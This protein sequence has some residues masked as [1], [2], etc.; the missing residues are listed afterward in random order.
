MLGKHALATQPIAG[1]LWLEQDLSGEMAAGASLAGRASIEIGAAGIV[2][3]AVSA[4]EGRL[5]RASE[6]AGVIAALSDAEALILRHRLVGGT[7]AATSAATA[8]LTQEEAPR[9]RILIATPE[10]SDRAIIT[11]GSEMPAAPASNLQRMQ[12]E[13]VWIAPDLD[14]AYLVIDLGTAQ[15]I[16]LISLL[17]TNASRDAVLRV[18]AANT[19]ADLTVDPGFDVSRPH[20][21]SPNLETWERTHALVWFPFA[22]Q[23]YRFWRIDIHDPG[24]PDGFYQAGRLYLANAWQPTLN[25]AYDWSIGSLDESEFLRGAGGQTYPLRRDPVPVLDFSIH[26]IGAGAEDEAF[27]PMYDLERRRGTTRDALVVVD[28]HSPWVHQL[29]VY[30]LFRELQPVTNIDF[31]HYEK[32]FRVEG[33]T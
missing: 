5:S 6:L 11:A 23:T 9:A 16:T 17:Y 25:I 14:N 28:A 1:R 15:T 4:A 18:R 8:E 22:P 32:R 29:M 21:P 31:S 26:A 19:Q 33:L 2:P 24:N 7:M 27:G 13:D 3:A 20:W 10:I 30:G 12:P